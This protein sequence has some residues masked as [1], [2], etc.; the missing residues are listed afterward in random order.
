[1]IWL[2]VAV[3]STT[4]LTN[5]I[6]IILWLTNFRKYSSIQNNLPKVSILIPARNEELNIRRCLDSAISLNYPAEQLEILVGN[7][8]S[9]DKTLEI[10]NSFKDN[11][12]IRIIPIEPDYNGLKGKA[13][14]LAQLAKK[15]KGEYYFMTDADIALP[16]NWIQQHLG[17]MQNRVG[18]TVGVT[19]VRDSPLQNIDWIFSISMLKVVTDLGGFVTGIGNNMAVS[20]QAYWSVGGYENIPFSIIEDYELSKQ[21]KQKGYQCSLI[22]Q[23]DALAISQP[24][25]GFTNLLKQ[26]KRWMRGAVQLPWFM[27]LL[28][29]IQ[30][31]FSVAII[32]L[33]FISFSTALL[34]FI[35]KW[36][37][38][39]FF[40]KLFSNK[41]R[42]KIRLLDTLL[43]E[44]YY[45]V[46]SICT[47]IYFLIPGKIKWKGR[48][49]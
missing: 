17:A 26:R 33:S 35:A 22:Y 49:Y 40:I 48:H 16:K 30:G 23:L 7:D 32:I 5:I 43:F 20:K 11:S 14:V 36:I 25:I 44:L 6:L 12:L 24:I 28:L 21:I 42:V 37:T 13:N 45:P 34:I 41:I 39:F 38:Q 46:V 19:G 2:L 47:I 15:A 10:I 29:F 3:C 18:M 8:D 1:M 4:L 27:I 9:Q 31:V